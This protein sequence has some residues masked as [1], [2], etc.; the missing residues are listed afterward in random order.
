[1]QAEDQA[2]LAALVRGQRQASLGT[3][4]AGVPFV[5]MV[6]YVLAQGEDGQPGLLLHLSRL[7]PHTGHLLA[8]P[9]ASLLIA[10]PDS[11]EGDPQALPRVTI[12]VQ[13]QAI[14]ADSTAY[15]RAKAAYIARLPQAEFLFT[16][17]DFVLFQLQP[18]AARY[19]GG[20]ARAFALNAEQFRAVLAEALR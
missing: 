1:M 20:Y 3:L 4:A 8:E 9:R 12:E 14:A 18:G 2:A 7:S 15:A 5:S 13:A 6:L 10:Q 17:P 19:I 16:F 11:G